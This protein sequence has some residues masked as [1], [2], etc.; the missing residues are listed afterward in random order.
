[1]RM[2]KKDVK[3]LGIP[4]N[5]DIIPEGFDYDNLTPSEWEID[6]STNMPD[7][8]YDVFYK[9]ASKSHRMSGIVVKDGEFVLKPT[10][11]TI[12]RI[13]GIVDWLGTVEEPGHYFLERIE[14]DIEK[15]CYSIW[16][17]S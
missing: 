7:G 10:L 5:W 4:I 3:A 13:A 8:E 12:H 17:G 2:R 9:Q 1:M 11:K 14:W 15:G 16:M 6:I